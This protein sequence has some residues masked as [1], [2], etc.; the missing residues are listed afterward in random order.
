M[1]PIRAT[2]T[3]PPFR[4]DRCRSTAARIMTGPYPAVR[5]ATALLPPAAARRAAASCSRLAPARGFRSRALHHRLG[6]SRRAA[7][8][9]TAIPLAPAAF[10]GRRPRRRAAG[11]ISSSSR[12]VVYGHFQAFRDHHGALD[13]VLQAGRMLLT[14]RR[15]PFR[16][17]IA[18]SSMPDDLLAGPTAARTAARSATPR[19]GT[20]SAPV[21]RAADGTVIGKTHSRRWS[22]GPRGIGPGGSALPG[23]DAWPR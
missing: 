2:L 1:R 9:T 10:V 17:T 20:S 6:Q 19:S 15:S 5:A 23:S 4:A 16:R 11:S 18:S 13:H 7:A 22:T 21:I 12:Q 3:L 14:A 8:T